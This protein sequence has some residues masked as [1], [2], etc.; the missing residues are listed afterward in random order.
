MLVSTLRRTALAGTLCLIGCGAIYDRLG[1]PF[2]GEPRELFEKGTLDAEARALIVDAFSGFENDT[3]H[4]HHVHFF[5]NGLPDEYTYCPELGDLDRPWMNFDTFAAHQ[6]WWVRPFVRGIY[7]DALDVDDEE[8]MDDQFMK[9]LVDLVAEHGSPEYAQNP[10]ASPFRTLFYVMAMD[11][12]YGVDGELD[13]TGLAFVPNEYVLRLVECLN[14][15]LDATGRFTR[16]R[17][18]PVGSVNPLRRDADGALVMRDQASWTRELDLLKGRV[19]WIKWRPGT[20][21]IDP[22]AVCDE[23]YVELARRDIGILT[24]TG[25]SKAVGLSAELDRFAAPNRMRRAIELGVSVG[26]LHIGRA[27]EN[28]CG[29]SY[30]DEFFDILSEYPDSKLF[31]EISAVPYSDSTALMKRVVEAGPGRLINGSDYP[32]VTPYLLVDES[33]EDLVECGYLER[34]QA[35]SLDRIYRYNPLLFDFVLK[36]TLRVDGAA[37]PRA[38]FLGVR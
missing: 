25:E 21:S 31:G 26:M 11:G 18:V 6:P 14:A 38:T 12:T 5:G 22:T 19:Q 32:A 2:E 10:A 36:R 3:L 1:G 28:E 37:V 8:R 4:D 17:F 23:F 7:L 13:T 9:R 35:R 27:G 30:A 20:M 33:L 24:H 15:K 29:V 16:N 34:E